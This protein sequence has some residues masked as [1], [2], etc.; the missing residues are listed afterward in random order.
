MSGVDTPSRVAV[1]EVAQRTRRVGL[2]AARLEARLVRMHGHLD[3]RRALHVEH[4]RP[5]KAHVAKRG[6]AS[7]APRAQHTDG[8]A[9]HLHEGCARHQDLPLDDVLKH[10]H[11]DRTGRWC[12]EEGPAV[13]AGQPPA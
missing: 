11:A 13:G 1:G 12:A 2:T 6:R 3:Q 10:E 8:G 5:N 4:E 7:R 9:R